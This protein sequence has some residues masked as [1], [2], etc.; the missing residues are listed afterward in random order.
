MVVYQYTLEG[1]PKTLVQGLMGQSIVIRVIDKGFRRE[2]N[3][4]IDGENV[5]KF[6][7]P[8]IELVSSYAYIERSIYA[9]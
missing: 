6:E 2:S 5:D 1:K 9:E 4:E 7:S 8:D 3:N